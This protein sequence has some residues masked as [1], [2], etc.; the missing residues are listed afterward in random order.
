M[1]I[2]D[3]LNKIFT[4]LKPVGNFLKKCFKWMFSNIK[5]LLIVVIT[6][7]LLITAFNFYT[8]K[9]ELEKTKI[10]L[11]EANDTTFVYKNKVG[12]L[13][14]ARETYIASI[15]D[16]KTAN[17][18][19][20]KEYKNLKEHPIVVEKVETIIKIDSIKVKDSLVVDPQKNTYTSK[21]E[22]NEKWC[23]L[24]GTTFVDANKLSSNTTL[25]K[26][27]FPATFTTD[28]IEKDK[29]LFFLTKCDNP[30]VQINNIQGAVISPEQSKVLKERFRRPW[31]IM[32][33]VGPSV[34]VVNNTVKIYPSL[35][36]TI[37]Y[38]VIDF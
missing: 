33:G 5:N 1:N 15:K 7:L 9:R 29:K 17:E 8:T 13:Y 3:I 34:T 14:K 22:Y 31:G 30:Y 28:I 38:K 19:L 23:N 26:I 32:V 4:F 11:V 27:V 24:S 10:E 12:E 2:L 36:L 20:Y 25:N 6:I 16:L 21:F 37:G 18:E 35:Q